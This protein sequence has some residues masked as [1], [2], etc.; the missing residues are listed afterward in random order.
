MSKFVAGD[1]N[2]PP[3]IIS[4]GC[5]QLSNPPLPFCEVTDALGSNKACRLETPSYYVHTPILSSPSNDALPLM[6][7]PTTS[8]P[9][10]HLLSVY[11]LTTVMRAV[12]PQR[13]HVQQIGTC[14]LSQWSNMAF[15]CSPGKK[16]AGDVSTPRESQGYV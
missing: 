2:A 6:A 14:G 16:P 13:I 8:V 10:E 11:G 12:L 9:A 15:R 4:G 5:L 7:A 1:K 3:G